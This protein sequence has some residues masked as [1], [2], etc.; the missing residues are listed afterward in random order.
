MNPSMKKPQDPSAEALACALRTGVRTSTARQWGWL[1][2]EPPKLPYRAM[3][4]R[5][6]GDEPRRAPEPARRAFRGLTA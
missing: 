4:F 3:N 1:F 6:P 2:E 5:S